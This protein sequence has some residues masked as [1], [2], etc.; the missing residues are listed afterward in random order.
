MLATSAKK[1]KK[2]RHARF[3]M[4]KKKRLLRFILWCFKKSSGVIWKSHK[5][6]LIKMLLVGSKESHPMVRINH[7]AANKRCQIRDYDR[8]EVSPHRRLAYLL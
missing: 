1:T 5:T 3:L 2:N 7:F 4:N 8:A 6:Y